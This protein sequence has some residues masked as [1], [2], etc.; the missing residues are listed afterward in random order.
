MKFCQWLWSIEKTR[1]LGYRGAQ[2]GTEHLMNIM[3]TYLVLDK[4][5]DT[6]DGSGS[7]LGDGSG[8][9]THYR[10]SQYLLLRWYR[11]LL[12][13]GD[14]NKRS[15]H[16]QK[17][18]LIEL[19][20]IRRTQEVNDE[21][22]HAHEGPVG[23]LLALSADS[24]E[25]L[26]RSIVLLCLVHLCRKRVSSLIPMPRKCRRIA[27]LQEQLQWTEDLKLTGTSFLR[28]CGCV[29]WKITTKR[30]MGKGMRGVVVDGKME[31]K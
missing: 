27:K 9:T 20:M 17:R 16:S 21:T 14:A 6:L 11:I 19:L 30:E 5:L 15:S 3:N 8:N 1:R 23:R 7:S 28:H 4:K 2:E 10:G 18:R 29:V 12:W 24:V 31:K 22:R 13:R 26:E 25:E